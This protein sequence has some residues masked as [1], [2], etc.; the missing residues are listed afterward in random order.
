MASLYHLISWW[1]GILGDEKILYVDPALPMDASVVLQLV[2]WNSSYL[3]FTQ[4]SRL[5]KNLRA[6]SASHPVCI[7]HDGLSHLTWWQIDR[8][9]DG[10]GEY[11]SQEWRCPYVVK[12]SPF[13][14]SSTEKPATRESV[15]KV[16]SLR[17]DVTA[18]DEKN[19]DLFWARYSNG[20]DLDS[21]SD[22]KFQRATPGSSNGGEPFNI[23]EQARFLQGHVVTSCPSCLML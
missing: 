21:D 6:E 20:R 16:F 7:A 19:K 22:W 3:A 10:F 13:A 4:F 9:H 11:R 2:H 17:V 23:L 18:K 5:K 15:A 14:T 1:A 12:N 8:L